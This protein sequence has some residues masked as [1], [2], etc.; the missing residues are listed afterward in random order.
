ML[1]VTLSHY[2]VFRGSGVTTPAL[3]MGS[4]AAGLMTPHM[5]TGLQSQS[6]GCYISQVLSSLSDLCAENISKFRI[7]RPIS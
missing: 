7:K 5:D 2:A 6:A 1:I 3:T 4:P